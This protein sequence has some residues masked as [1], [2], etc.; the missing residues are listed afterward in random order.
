MQHIYD[1]MEFR[2][3]FFLTFLTNSLLMIYLPLWQ[4]WLLAGA[5]TKR[6]SKAGCIPVS[7]SEGTLSTDDSIINELCDDAFSEQV[8]SKDQ[9][10]PL[11]SFS[12]SH[13]V[14]NPR[15]KPLLPEEEEDIVPEQGMDYTHLDVIKVAIVIAPLYVLS[16][17]LYNYSLFMTSVSSST[18]IR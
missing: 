4:V 6:S 11:P 14:S 7:G 5:V 10:N 18:I 17:G 13:G 3:P 15:T 9:Y 16:N 8:S 12:S 2:S 1:D